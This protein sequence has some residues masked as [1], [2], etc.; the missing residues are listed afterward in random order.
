MVDLLSDAEENSELPVKSDEAIEGL[1]ARGAKKRTLASPAE[2]TSEA[3]GLQ[4]VNQKCRC[5]DQINC[6]L[7][8]SRATLLVIKIKVR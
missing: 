3:H 8:F 1:S 4:I 5:K 2:P 7:K 6:F